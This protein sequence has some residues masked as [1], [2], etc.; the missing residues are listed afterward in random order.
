MMSKVRK[1]LGTKARFSPLLSHIFQPREL[2]RRLPLD[3]LLTHCAEIVVCGGEVLTTK[4][5][6][7]CR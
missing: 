7:V 3:D 1:I 5:A 4:E 2:T 6:S